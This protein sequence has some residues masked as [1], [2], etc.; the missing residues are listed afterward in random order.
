MKLMNYIF[1]CIR[2]IR[3]YINY[4]YRGPISTFAQ[5]IKRNVNTKNTMMIIYHVHTHTYKK[6]MTHA[7]EKNNS[8]FFQLRKSTSVIKHKKKIYN[9][10]AN[11][12][13]PTIIIVSNSSGHCLG[14]A[15]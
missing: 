6:T 4:I 7:F 13:I 9:S 14:Q 2:R 15:Y 5:S 3:I 1:I 11:K 8:K 10:V 12:L